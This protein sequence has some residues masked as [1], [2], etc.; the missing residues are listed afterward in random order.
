M[1]F[2]ALRHAGAGMALLVLAV[3]AACAQTGASPMTMHP[4]SIQPET[5]L[6]VSAESSVMVDPDVAYIT[7]GVETEEAT[8]QAAMA[9]NRS[10]MNSVFEV[11]KSAG[12]DDRDMQ[13]SNFQIYPRYEYVKVQS[14][15]SSSQ[16]QE[17]Q[18]YRVSNQLTIKVRDLDAL[19]PTLDALV[20]AGGNTFAGLRFALDDDTGVL[21]QA[22]EQAVKA[23]MAR[24]DLL[25]S[26]AGYRVG[27]IVTMN[28]NSYNQGPQPLMAMARAESADFAAT[29]VAAGEV[30]Y[31]AA[32]NV[33]VEL[34]R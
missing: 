7:A 24:A 8:A 15:S 17:L 33:T 31:T 26:A 30:G 32:V 14:S 12:I 34:V 29:P 4:N 1:L 21:D 6:S 10:A 16:R 3:P 13:T 19:G 20:E 22:R 5:T 2:P 11:L 9:A 27:R 18:G 23:A 25:A 28:E